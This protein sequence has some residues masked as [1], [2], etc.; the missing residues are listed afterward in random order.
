MLKLGLD[1]QGVHLAMKT[2]H[3]T[4]YSVLINGEPQGYITPSCGIKQGDPLSPHLFLL[5]VKGLSSLIRKAIETQQLHGILSYTNEVCISHLLF[6][7][8]SFIFYQATMEEGQHL[9]D[10]LEKYEA[11]FSQA[12]NRQKNPSSLAKIQGIRLKWIFRHFCGAEL[13]RIV[14]LTLACL[15]LVENQK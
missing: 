11:A 13:W 5:C 9:P 7:D 15:R 1:A 2:V 8:N 10:I 3:T 14:K 4:T 12:I 6:V